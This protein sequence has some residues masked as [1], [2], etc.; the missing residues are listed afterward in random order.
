MGDWYHTYSIV[1]VNSYLNPSSQWSD[2]FDV[3]AL[4]NNL[5]MNNRNTWNC[6]VESNTFLPKKNTCVCNGGSPYSTEV[7]INISYQANAN[8]TMAAEE[9]TT[10]WQRRLFTSM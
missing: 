5:C 6:Q 4:A 8:L 9:Q 2:E 7:E 1:L 3:E 10:E